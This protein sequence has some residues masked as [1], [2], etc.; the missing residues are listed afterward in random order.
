MPQEQWSSETGWDV[1]PQLEEGKMT[2]LRR[3]GGEEETAC[4]FKGWGQGREVNS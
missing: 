4:L 1:G 2:Q 3:E